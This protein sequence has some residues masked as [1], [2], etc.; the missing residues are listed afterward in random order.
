MS[1]LAKDFGLQDFDDKDVA[2]NVTE[3][4]DAPETE[5]E[6]IV[7]DI[8][9]D[10]SATLAAGNAHKKSDKKLDRVKFLKAYQ[11]LHAAFSIQRKVP[12]DEKAI[13]YE[14]MATMISAGVPLISAVRVYADQATHRYFK[15]ITEAISYQLEKGQSLSEAMTE[16]KKIFSE[17]EIGIIEAAEATG[18][19]NEVLLRLAKQAEDSLALRSKIR[20]A[21][22]YPAIVIVFVVGAVY[23]MLTYVIPQIS[24]LFT[25]SGLELP[26]LTQ[27]L[28]TASD[29]VVNNG[30]LV[31][32][33][34][35]VA[36]FLLASFSKTTHGKRIFHTMYLRL[37]VL[38]DFQRS[39]YQ[40]RFA[41]SISNMLNSGVSIV[42]ACNITARSL[43]NVVYQKKVR[44][45]GKDVSRGIQMAESMQDS[46][47]FSNLMV[48]MFAVGERTAQL[49]DLAAKTADYYEAKVATMATNFSKIIQ[50]FIIAVVG[51]MV[52]IVVLAVM[53]P[54][55]EL[56]G[57]IEGL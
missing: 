18:R 51:G 54:M 46:P 4:Q 20:S 23:A 38:K 36:I 30:A 2:F 27:F 1:K 7:L 44:L 50:P 11:K 32:L 25:Q 56:L 48:S 3:T 24:T 39:I 42:E 9:G 12:L 53:L 13:F 35:V 15:K 22:I 47:Y 37:P 34:T 5:E 43:N 40:A 16:Y 29:F 52:G 28:I 6:A 26:F 21:M 8:I 33:G 14:L 10:D 49:D 41:R 45:I 57:G 17:A 31:L 19:L 55:T